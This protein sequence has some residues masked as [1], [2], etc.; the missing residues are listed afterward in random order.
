M[1]VARNILP[2]LLILQTAVA[3]QTPGFRSDTRLV[4][5]HATVTNSQGERVRTLD[6]RAFT[7]QENGKRQPITIFSRD[8]VPISVGLLIDNSGSMRQL[9]PKVEAAALAFARAS[10]PA[11]EIFVVNFNDTVRVDVPMTDDVGVLE[12]GIGRVDSIGG[13]ALRDAVDTAERYLTDHATRDRRVLLVITDGKDNASVTSA[14]RLRQQAERTQTTIFS[15]GLFN[16][17]DAGASMGRHELTQLTE[18][19]GGVVYF[20]AGIEQVEA[21]AIDIAHQIR[22]QYTIAYAPLDQ[23]LDGSYRTI[24][25]TATGSQHYTVHTRSGYRAVPSVP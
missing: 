23:S 2:A 22:N 19:T 15:I 7:V 6:Q 11:D 8:D 17:R 3:G 14:E 13:T 18:H 10:N 1:T 20:P 5:L 9:R 25:V 24:R 21:E 12:A 16:D 4:V